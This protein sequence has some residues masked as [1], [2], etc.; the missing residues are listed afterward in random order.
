MFTKYLLLAAIS[1][2]G[3]YIGSSLGSSRAW[4]A[5]ASASTTRIDFDQVF[6][7]AARRVAFAPSVINN[8]NRDAKND[9]LLTRGSMLSESVVLL[10]CEPIAAPFADPVLGKIVG[11]CDA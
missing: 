8:V 5:G 9:R 10:H 6:A 1:L 3:V 4:F 11:R 2:I 7:D